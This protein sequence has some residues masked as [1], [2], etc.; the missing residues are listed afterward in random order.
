VGWRSL[1]VALL[2]DIA[3]LVAARLGFSAQQF[4]LPRVLEGGTWAAGRRIA[5]EK[6]NDGGPPLRICSDGTVF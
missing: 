2:D 1:T 3:P 6:R 4:P 5:R